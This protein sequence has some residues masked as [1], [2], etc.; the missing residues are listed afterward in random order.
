MKTS[1]EMLHPKTQVTKG[2]LAEEAGELMRRFFQKL[3]NPLPI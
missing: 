1:S 3:R 2:V